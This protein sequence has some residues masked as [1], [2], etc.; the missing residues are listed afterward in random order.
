MKKF[1]L[2]LFA[3]ILLA[4]CSLTLPVGATSNTIGS[5]VGTSSGTCYWGLLCFD[6]DAGIQSAARSAGITKISTVDY[7]QKNVLN[8]VITHECIVTGE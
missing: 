4:S 2:P 5:K 1:F 7:R 8:I 6:A 3:S